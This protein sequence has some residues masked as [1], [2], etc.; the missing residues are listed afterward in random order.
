MKRSQIAWTIVT[1]A[2]LTVVAGFMAWAVHATWGLGG[3][4][5]MTIHG[6]IALVLAFVITGLLGGGLMFL[7][8]Y[9][10]RKGYDDNVG[11]DED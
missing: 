11:K 7:A 3:L 8:F 6:W 1:V 2:G 10:S 5:K 4:S 9:S